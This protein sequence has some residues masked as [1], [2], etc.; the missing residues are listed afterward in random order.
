MRQ[1]VILHLQKMGGRGTAREV[2]H[3]IGKA[4]KHVWPR[5][6]ELADAGKI[7]PCGRVT[8]QRGRPTVI[9]ADVATTHPLNDNLTCDD[10]PAA[11][12]WT[13]PAWFKGFG[14]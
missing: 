8:G 5:F 11:E 13:A 14:T 6:T 3:S 7:R 12:D 1:L 9:W 4:L 2:A 10:T